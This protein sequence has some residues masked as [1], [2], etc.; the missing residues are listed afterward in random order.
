[1]LILIVILRDTSS[2]LK[3]HTNNT[4]DTY[5]ITQASRLVMVCRT[6]TGVPKCLKE[7]RQ[8]KVT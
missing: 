3:R 8:P 2:S 4:K 5:N 7:V 6:I 1:V